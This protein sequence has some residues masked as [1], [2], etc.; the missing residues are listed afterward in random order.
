[1]KV[2]EKTCRVIFLI[3]FNTFT[4]GLCLIAVGG[5]DLSSPYKCPPDTFH[6]DHS[7]RYVNISTDSV[8][9][10]YDNDRYI[11]GLAETISG[12]TLMLISII[13]S[14]SF[15]R[16]IKVQSTLTNV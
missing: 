4:L 1:M 5:N 16:C 7:C 8:D 13:I 3:C 15:C 12:S 10:I 9:Y 6:I 2:S 11:S 14:I